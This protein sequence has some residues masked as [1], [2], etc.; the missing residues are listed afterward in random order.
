MGFP[1]PP[2]LFV[3]PRPRRCHVG[4]IV[5]DRTGSQTNFRATGRLHAGQKRDWD[6]AGKMIAR[7][8]RSLPISPDRQTHPILGRVASVDEQRVP[9]DQL[10]LECARSPRKAGERRPGTG[11][12]SHWRRTIGKVELE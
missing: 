3:T 6:S 9:H 11:A 7:F 2:A 4:G 8:R 5:G 12:G 10:G 1:I